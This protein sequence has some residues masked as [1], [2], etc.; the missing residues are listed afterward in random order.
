MIETKLKA[1]IGLF[2]IISHFAIVILIVL[3]YLLNGFLF[4]EMTT[5]I[6]L[7][8]PMFSIYST[9][10]IKYFVANR[11][12]ETVNSYN[13][14]KVTMEY[15]FITFLIPSLFVFFLIMLTILKSLNVGFSSFEQYKTMLALCETAFGA[16]IGIILSS[17]F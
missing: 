1:K 2:L 16:Y 8:I 5:A 15:T 11:N 10:I 13:S 7:I 9:A 12:E 14:K 17:L 3:L 6:A 4:H